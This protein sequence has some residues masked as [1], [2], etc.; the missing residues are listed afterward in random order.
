[1][2]MQVQ[3]TIEDPTHLKLKQPLDAEVGSVVIL[4]I[5]EDSD[6]NEFLTGSAALLERAYNDDE[7]D[8]SDSGAPIQAS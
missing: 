3:A 2:T 6:R 4:D 1:M 7:P 8:Y 5:V